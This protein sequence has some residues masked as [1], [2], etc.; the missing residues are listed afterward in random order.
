MATKIKQ[1]GFIKKRVNTEDQGGFQGLQMGM[2]RLRYSNA[3]ITSKLSSRRRK[4]SLLEKRQ[5]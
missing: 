3:P 2:E 4:P 5:D 1:Y